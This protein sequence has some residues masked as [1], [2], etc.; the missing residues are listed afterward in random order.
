M[1]LKFYWVHNGTQQ[2]YYYYKLLKVSTHNHFLQN[3]MSWTFQN[4]FWSDLIY[5]APIISAGH[6]KYILSAYT[7]KFLDP[8]ILCKAKY[9]SHQE[10]PDINRYREKKDLVFF[11][12]L[13]HWQVCLP[14]MKSSSQGVAENAVKGFGSERYY[15]VWLN[16][17]CVGGAAPSYQETSSTRSLVCLKEVC[18][19]HKV[20]RFDFWLVGGLG[21]IAEWSRW[22][23]WSFRNPL[24]RWRWQATY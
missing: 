22:D 5:K 10:G 12:Q 11:F 13:L 18:A 9:S 4:I 21:W 3:A 8:K 16:G 19:K 20:K 7:Q 14:V 6:F 15:S 23:T 2:Y 17:Y 1:F 24:H